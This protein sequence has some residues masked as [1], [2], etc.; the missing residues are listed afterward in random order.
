M[1]EIKLTYFDIDGGRGE[2]IRLALAIGKIHFEDHRFA[3]SDWPAIK[4]RMPLRQVPVMEV[5]GQ[6]ITQTN[7]MNRYVGKLAGLYPEDPLDA[8]HC[9]EAMATIEGILPQITPTYFIQ[10]EEEKR[11][12]REA[13]AD[14]PITLYL[15]RL[16]TM[17]SERGGR[18]FAGDRLSVADLK[19]FVWIRHLKSGALE[20]I[21]IDLVDRVAP[22]L[23]EHFERIGA[24]P[25]ILAYYRQRS[26]KNKS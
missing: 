25:G 3:I 22:K 1:P 11:L 6:A 2:P 12:A 15:S 24:H 16:E 9:D 21:P 19:V 4:D 8:L 10:D 13:L 14:G 5:N 26:D 20:Y 18:Y 7:S 17:L 23:V